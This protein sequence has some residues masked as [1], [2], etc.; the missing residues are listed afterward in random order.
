MTCRADLLPQKGRSR[1]KRSRSNVG[2]DTVASLEVESPEEWTGLVAG[3][4]ELVMPLH[5][6]LQQAN[7]SRH[8]LPGKAKK[9]SAKNAAKTK[10]PVANQSS[11]EILSP[12]M[13]T[14][15]VEKAPTLQ[16]STPK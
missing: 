5:Q 3:L 8:A 2:S 1:V 14:S 9:K 7:S 6:H 15:L 12:N 4:R 10:Q 13:L 16:V 11:S